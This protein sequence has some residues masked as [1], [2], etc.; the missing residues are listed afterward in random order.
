MS[1][2]N[3]VADADALMPRRIRYDKTQDCVRC[4]V[5][6]G[7]I[8]IRHAVYC[9]NCFFP[10]VSHKFRRALEPTVNLK[11]DG[12]RRTALKPAGNLLV[13]FSGGLGSTVLLDLIHQTYVSLENVPAQGGTEHPRHERVWPRVSVCY[14]ELCDAFPGLEDRTA[15]IAEHVSRHDGVEFVPL[16]IQDAFDHDWWRRVHATPFSCSLAVDMSSDEL[17]VD[18]RNSPSKSSPLDLLRAHLAS[19]PTP[20]AVV[21]TVQTLVRLLLLHTAVE[22]GSSHLVLGTSLTSLAVSLIQGVAQGRGFNVREEMQEEWYPYHNSEELK[23]LSDSIS[24]P[25][26]SRKR[27]VRVIRPLRDVGMKECAAWAW[28]KSLHI[29]GGKGQRWAAAK[30]QIG[31]LTKDFIVGLEKDYPSTVSTIVRTSG[32]LAP[33]GEV[34]GKCIMCER[35]V[36]EG[37][38]QWKSRIS[39][40]SLSPH[41][42]EGSSHPSDRTHTA[43]A[44]AESL[45]PH[46]CYACHTDFS[47]RTS[48]SAPPLYPDLIKNELTPM[49][50]WLESSWAQQDGRNAR[51][52]SRDDMRSVIGE[53]LLE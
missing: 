29:V 15:E 7:N 19:L 35:P 43:A 2:G 20:T 51:A 47:S 11:P 24:Q 46:L 10:L 37:V 23:T 38:Q 14:V 36:Q 44:A 26:A 3:P 18:L 1:C 42:V 30:Q 49:P 21:S 34:A 48:R 13:G 6:R 28:W 17:P 33:R 12:P 25:Q 41:A 27:S 8:V 5:S 31:S 39:I 32:K 45:T 9:K 40:R 4:K 50:A 22:T 53:F 52:M 16:R